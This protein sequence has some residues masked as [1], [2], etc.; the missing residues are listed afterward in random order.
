VTAKK[1]DKKKV[2]VCPTTDKKKS[3]KELEVKAK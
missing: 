3:S 2:E 1:R